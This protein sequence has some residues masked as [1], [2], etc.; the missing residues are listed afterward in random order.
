MQGNLAVLALLTQ[1][2]IAVLDLLTL[3]RANFTKVTSPPN[4]TR[5]R[6][7]SYL[8]FTFFL[9]FLSIFYLTRYIPPDFPSFFFPWLPCHFISFCH[10]ATTTTTGFYIGRPWGQHIIGAHLVASLHP[11]VPY[12]WDVPEDFAGSLIGSPWCREVTD[13]RTVVRLPVVSISARGCCSMT[14]R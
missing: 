2:N 6:F 7:P 10:R 5:R 1:G 12:L 13:F 4:S 11:T 8:L 14:T 3:L 9:H